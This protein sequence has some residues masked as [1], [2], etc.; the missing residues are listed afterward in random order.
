[1]KLE[2]AKLPYRKNISLITF[3]ENRFLLVN[4]INWPVDFWKFAQG[5]I[6]DDE[7]IFEAG[8]REFFEEIGSKKIKIIGLSK[9]ENKYDWSDNHIEE[10]NNKWRGQDQRFLLIEF[11]GDDADIKIDPKELKDYK[12]VSKEDILSYSKDLNH[13][14]FC[15]YNGV[16]EKIF[17]EFLL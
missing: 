9:F 10:H 1:M 8:K 11:L 6:N 4:R 14:L 3:K 13:K 15:N 17:E 5:G 7:D 16:I 12:W 2:Y